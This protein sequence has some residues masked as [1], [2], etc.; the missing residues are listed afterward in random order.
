M[1]LIV[2]P[3]HS[4]ESGKWCK[5]TYDQWLEQLLSKS[6][7]HRHKH[8]EEERKRETDIQRERETNTNSHRHKFHLTFEQWKNK[9]DRIE[10]GGKKK[11][12]RTH[13]DPKM[14]ACGHHVLSCVPCVQ[15]LITFLSLSL[16]LS[17]SSFSFSISRTW[18]FVSLPYVSD[19]RDSS[20]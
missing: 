6:N 19:D 15:V 3:V 10:E 7:T 2:C 5:V 11:N 14:I 18:Q 1:C 12:K 8:R 16:S 9:E 13:L 4:L 17:L 20:Q